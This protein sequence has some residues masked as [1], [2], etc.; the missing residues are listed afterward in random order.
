[1]TYEEMATRA[2]VLMWIALAFCLVEVLIGLARWRTG[3]KR[4]A[5]L[6]LGAALA[7]LAFLVRKSS[8]LWLTAIATAYVLVI[9]WRVRVARVD[10]SQQRLKA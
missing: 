4:E 1:M 5:I 3:G 6:A 2:D 7:P 9:V 10:R 8:G